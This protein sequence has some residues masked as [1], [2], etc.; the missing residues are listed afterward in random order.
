MPT[1]TIYRK[2]LEKAVGRKLPD[3]ILKNRLPMLGMQLENIDKNNLELEIFP[4]RPDML[5]LQ[6]LARALRSYFGIKMGLVQYK[7]QKSNY[8]IYID[9]NV[10]MRPYTACAVVKNIRFTDE[11]I[12]DIMQI[13]EKL[14]MTHGRNR[15]KSAYGLY[16]AD[17]IN[18]PLKYIAKNPKE[19]MF[20]PLGFDKPI[21]ADKVE[22]LHKTGKMYKH[23]AKDWELY[24]FFIDAKENVLCMLPYT[25]SEDTGKITTE[26]K[27]VF[28]ECTGNDFENL[29]QALTILTTMLADM[30]GTI[31]EVN[32]HYGTK[33][34]VT[35]N[36]QPR[37]Q[38][39]NL[40]RAN[41]IL[42]LKLKEN[43]IKKLLER[44]G[45]SYKKGSAMVPAYRADILHEDDVIEDIAIAY[46]FD[47]FEPV[48]PAFATVSKENEF[49]T[50]KNKIAE[51]LI[52][53]DMQEVMNY[54]LLPVDA[55]FKSGFANKITVKDSKSEYN[56]LRPSLLP[57]MLLTLSSNQHYSYP[58]N[59]FEMGSIFSVGTSETGV[60]ETAHLGIILCQQDSDFTKIK[61]VAQYLMQ[62]LGVNASFKETSHNSLISGRTSQISANGKSVGTLG[63][64]HPEILSK[65]KLE[66]P[67]AYLEIDLVELF[68]ISRR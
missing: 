42:G 60:V 19:V 34:I 5:S 48:L 63:E 30:G 66:M 53:L 46:G 7:V 24:P 47:N 62:Q 27:N 25:N 15:K 14:A 10:T 67:A 33:K 54:H 52:G 23:I 61:Q 43:E 41:K 6:G 17:K 26:T 21:R 29:Q 44:M 35:P 59:L 8:H 40:D 32:L 18:F 28:I 39:I 9:K 45:Y 2:E 56:S 49:E 65:N 64:V 51:I 12:K 31:Y 1:I 38:N 11:R 57:G 36:L 37:K 13:Q 4:N 68:N 22:E 50:F 3:E 20:H 55:I 58:Q 16:P